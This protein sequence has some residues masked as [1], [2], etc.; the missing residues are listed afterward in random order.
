[1][2]SFALKIMLKGVSLCFDPTSGDNNEYLYYALINFFVF[3][4]SEFIPI[5]AWTTLKKPEDYIN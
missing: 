2:I 3:L 1:M 5:T 4:F